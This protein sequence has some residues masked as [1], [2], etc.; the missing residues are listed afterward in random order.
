[1]RLII[2]SLLVFGL[3][4][5]GCFE[6]PIDQNQTNTTNNTTIIQPVKT[7]SFTITSPT[8]YE[9]IY[10]QEETADVTLSFNTQNLVLKQPGGVA[11]SGEGHFKVTVDADPAV[12]ITSKNYVIAG[13]GLGEHTISV[14]LWTNDK[15]SYGI[16]KQVTFTVEKEELPAYEPQT[17]T[18]TI[19]DFS[20]SP[21]EL[22]VKR[23]DS[24]IF[25]NSGNFP[26]S[27]TCFIGGAEV[28]DT[29]VL[30]PGKNATIVMNE[31]LSCEYYAVT[32]PIMK[33]MIIVEPNGRED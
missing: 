26:R 11:K 29:E 32:H 33:G 17:Y 14:D 23:T 5:F 19:N 28:F 7:P 12:T 3:L 6:P 20:Y 18:V 21:A 10:T 25:V 2:L 30:G 31:V 1:M 8:S 15:K 13:L 16:S 27:A 24:V 22:T 4:L 9:S